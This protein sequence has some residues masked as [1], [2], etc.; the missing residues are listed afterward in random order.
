MAIPVYG[1]VATK[2]GFMVLVLVVAIRI[3]V[4]LGLSVDQNPGVNAVFTLMVVP[5]AAAAMAGVVP[6]G[7]SLSTALAAALVFCGS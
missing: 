4:L 5:S 1:A 7:S 6:G 3:P 2:A